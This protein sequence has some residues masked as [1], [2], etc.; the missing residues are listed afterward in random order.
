MP[1]SNAIL[2]VRTG[3]SPLDRVN[4]QTQLIV[5]TIYSIPTQTSGQQHRNQFS[6]TCD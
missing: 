1:T 4:Q 2:T 5:H 6:N 3:L